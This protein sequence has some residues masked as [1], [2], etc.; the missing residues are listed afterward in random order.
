MPLKPKHISDC[1][2]ARAA[3]P[4]RSGGGR[5]PARP[6]VWAALPGTAEA[7]TALRGAG[8]AGGGSPP[9]G[10]LSPGGGPPPRGTARPTPRPPCR[11]CPRPSAPRTAPPLHLHVPA[12]PRRG[13]CRARPPRPSPRARRSRAAAPATPAPKRRASPA[14][15]GGFLGDPLPP[16]PALQPEPGPALPLLP[17][18]TAG[19]QRGLRCARS[20]AQ[21]EPARTDRQRIAPA[22]T[23]QRRAPRLPHGHY[24]KIN[25]RFI[26]HI[27]PSKS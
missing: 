10:L 4:H 3:R 8:L 20:P 19:R 1:E 27:S 15:R 12:P 21:S 16:P 11:T 2:S 6:R 22:P 26:K 23:A 14:R 7:A 24:H 25:E 17:L 18:I 5:G 9:R 13:A